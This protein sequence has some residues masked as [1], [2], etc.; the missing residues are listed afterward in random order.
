MKGTA[1]KTIRKDGSDSRRSRRSR[2]SSSGRSTSTR[3]KAV[4]CSLLGHRGVARV[5][6]RPRA[7]AS[8]LSNL[9]LQFHT[10]VAACL[11]N[12]VEHSPTVTSVSGPIRMTLL[13]KSNL[14]R[15]AAR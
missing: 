15:R 12:T 2:R 10:D 14:R 9:R 13:F 11:W 4:L 1:F 5:C 8:A 6:R 7:P 3:E